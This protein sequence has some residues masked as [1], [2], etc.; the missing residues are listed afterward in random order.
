MSTPLYLHDIPVKLLG[1][2]W[3]GAWLETPARTYLA[4]A[5]L[6]KGPAACLDSTPRHAKLTQA[7]PNFNWCANCDRWEG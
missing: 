5:P 6:K 7:D 2:D 3:W 4:Y 1:L